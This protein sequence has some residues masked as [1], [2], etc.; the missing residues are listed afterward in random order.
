MPYAQQT[1]DLINIYDPTFW[2]QETLGQ[3]FP[4]LR[5][6]NMV[7]RGFDAEVAAKGDVVNTRMPNRFTASDVDPDAFASNRP[8][9]DNV[10][11]KMDTWKQVVFEIGDKEATLA[12]KDL[13][14]EFA[15]PAARA[16]A[17][18]I[19]DAVIGL[20]K[21]IPTAIGVAGTT[22]ATVAAL[23]TDIQ[24]K[25]GDMQIDDSG[26]N[27]VLNP[28]AQNKFNQVF[29]QDYVSGS[30]EQ[31][32]S[33]DLRPKFGMGFVGSNKLP[34]HVCGTAW[35]SGTV[36]IN[37]GAGYPAQ[38]ENLGGIWQSQTIA[39][40]GMTVSGTI[41][42]G[43]LLTLNHGGSIGVVT[44]AITA[45]TTANGAGLATV[46]IT[47]GLRAAVID[48]Q[49]VTS[50]GN[51]AVNLAFHDKAFCLI[52]R[53]MVAPTAPGANV[54]VVNFGGIGLRTSVWYEPK[55]IRTYVR[56]DGLFG[57]K[58]LDARKAFRVLG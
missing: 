54:S 34:S 51:H 31:Q 28:A 8:K 50:V 10:Q 30:T 22:P 37:N 44:Y 6:S 3:L 26:R 29:Y 17:E 9:A 18:V 49:A 13:Q 11:V 57:V 36:L 27:V 41:K 58:T 5:M 1:N 32:T 52:S 21:D 55:D 4:Q 15:F 39:I 43:D 20:Y 19:E 23:G 25:F 35:A 38:I 56:I 46:S 53:P 45:D 48:N 2:A 7:Y 33:G 16:L 14:S 47:P 24:Q 12:I 40:D 42:K